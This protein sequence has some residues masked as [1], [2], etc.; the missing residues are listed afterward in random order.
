M[1]VSRESYTN[2][3]E[4]QFPEFIFFFWELKAK[5]KKPWP[6]GLT[7]RCKFA[8]SEL[9]YGFGMGGQMN[10][11]VGSQV[12]NFTYIQMTCDQLVST[13]HENALYLLYI[14]TNHSIKCVA[15]LELIQETNSVWWIW[16]QWGTWD[17]KK[18]PMATNGFDVSEEKRTLWESGCVK[19][20]ARL[21][22]SVLWRRRASTGYRQ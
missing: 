1:A 18:W 14:W 7:S 15:R 9:A 11:Q 22:T 3:D 8:K 17:T 19:Y 16:S 10:S 21:P 6:N 20:V 5:C 13:S 4:G 2:A 12:V